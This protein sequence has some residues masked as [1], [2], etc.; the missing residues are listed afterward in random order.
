MEYAA[1][2]EE[3]AKAAKTRRAAKRRGRRPGRPVRNLLPRR[4]CPCPPAPA[5]PP[6]Q[7]ARRICYDEDL[8]GGGRRNWDER[9]LYL[10]L[11]EFQSTVDRAMAVR[12]LAYT[13]LL[14]QRLAADG[15]LRDPGALPPV[16]PVVIYKRPRVVD[17]TD[18]G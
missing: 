14:Y 2:G 8:D 4:P 18:R 11:L 17:G 15:T 9:W 3:A 10:L 7:P 1:I 13:A 12:M 16:L 5:P 6:P